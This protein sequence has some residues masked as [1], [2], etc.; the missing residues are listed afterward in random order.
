MTF[1][2]SEEQFLKH[3]G[4]PRKSGRYPWGSGGNVEI[5]NKRNRDF[6]DLVAWQRKEG[7]TDKQIYEG[8]GITSTQFRARQAIAN[9]QVKQEK[10]NTVNRLADTGMSNNAI[11]R[12]MGINES[13]VRSL[14]DPLAKLALRFSQT[15]LKFSS[16]RLQKRPSSTLDLVPST[17]STSLK[18]NSRSLWRFCKKRAMKYI[19]STS[20]NLVLVSQPLVKSS[21]LLVRLGLMLLGTR[22]RYDSSTSGQTLAAR[23]IIVRNPRFQ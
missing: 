4:T 20:S 5:E 15:L 13:S 14:L 1:V 3:Y 6:L 19:S 22:A 10:I 23:L 9:N 2:I 17:A 12:E 7:M 11:A 18:T 8:M 21:R 16:E